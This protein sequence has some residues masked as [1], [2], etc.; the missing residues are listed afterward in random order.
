MRFRS[1]QAN[2]VPER[3]AY[4]ERTS[5]KLKAENNVTG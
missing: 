2:T 5:I 3:P 1:V 4:S